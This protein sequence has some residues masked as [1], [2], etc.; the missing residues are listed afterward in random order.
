MLPNDGRVVSNFIIQALKGDDIT[1]YGNGMQTRSFQYVTDLIEGMLLMMKGNF[2]GP[3]NIGNP[4]EYTIRQLAE[5]VIRLTDSKSKIV[6][7]QLPND[8]P[9]RRK[10]DI[11]KAAEFLGYKPQVPLV[12]GLIKTIQYFKYRGIE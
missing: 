7:E 3:I 9:K 2:I 12:E 1:I 6:Y 11:S 10:P 4:E 8:D 5:E